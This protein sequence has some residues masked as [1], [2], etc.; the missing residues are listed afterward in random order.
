M[1]IE[2]TTFC[3]LTKACHQR[4][5]GTPRNHPAVRS[6]YLSSGH[7]TAAAT[8]ARSGNAATTTPTAHTA[9]AMMVLRVSRSRQREC[10][11]GRE[12]QFLHFHC[13]RVLF[14]VVVFWRTN[15]RVTTTK[16][17]M[18]GFTGTWPSLR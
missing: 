12:Y 17:P 10:N 11:R 2:I 18:H 14:F 13:P 16:I 4:I 9:A 1:V 15:R 7:S 3:Q 8:D 6:D 5:P